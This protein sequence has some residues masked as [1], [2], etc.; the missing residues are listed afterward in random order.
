M[1]KQLVRWLL[2]LVAIVVIATVMVVNVSLHMARAASPTT[3]HQT[4]VVSPAQPGKI[5]PDSFWHD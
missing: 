5:V 1:K 3:S 4:Q 2:P